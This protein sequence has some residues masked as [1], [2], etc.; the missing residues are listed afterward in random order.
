MQ[1]ARVLIELDAYLTGELEAETSIEIERHLKECSACGAELLTLK[2]ENLVYRNYRSTIEVPTGAWDEVQARMALRDGR[3]ESGPGRWWM[4]AAAASILIVT[5]LSWHSYVK[6]GLPPSGG[7]ST[8]EQA[9]EARLPVDQTVRDLEQSLAPLR[10]AYDEKK[11]NLDPQLVMELDQNLA[12]TRVA[13][14][15]CERALKEDPANRQAVEFLLLGYEKQISILRQI[16][17]EI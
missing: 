2:D 5:A 7:P 16:T 8:V 12:L 10:A 15:E 4:W 13:I 17:E 6:R 14:N 3:R 1:C 9:S 11:P